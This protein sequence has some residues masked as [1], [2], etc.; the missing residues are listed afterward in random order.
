MNFISISISVIIICVILIASRRWAIIAMTAGVL[1]LTQHISVDVLGFNIFPSR[2]ME[3]AG[4][5]RIIA[6]REFSFS[7]LN[8]IDRIFLLLYSYSTI[9]FILRSNEGQA[10]AIGSA[11][12]ATFCYFIFRGLISDI[13][14]FRW[15]LR[16][17]A[18]LL[19]P[20]VCLLFVEMQTSQNPFSLLG[21]VLPEMFREGRVRCM[22]SFRHP[23]LMGSLGASF[24]PLYIGLI[25]SRSMRIYATIG[26]ILCLGIVWFSNSGGPVG[27]AA[28]GVLG[29]SMWPY[30]DR[31]R[32]VRRVAV[33]CIAALVLIMKAPIWYL[34]TH[35]SISGDAW[36]R[37]HLMDVAVHHLGEW[38]LW[39]MPLTNTSEWFAYG[40]GTADQADITNQFVSFGLS[41][42][43]IS[44]V[45]FV[46][47]LTRAF[48]N[49]GRKLAEMRLA[50]VWSFE[51]ECL[52]WGL[53]VMLVGHITNFLAITYFDQFYVIWFMQLAF[54]SNLTMDADT[55]S[56]AV[57]SKSQSVGQFG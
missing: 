38:W 31:M 21:K 3:I 41:A 25:F 43:L 47:L 46:W 37:S 15:F 53:G 4:L 2:F 33:I 30:R 40:L 36:H 16:A 24:L 26:I 20:Y 28:A 11:V 19:I 6:R 17:F 8:S 7:N 13:D 57:P 52:L 42:G 27:F 1:Y 39:G 44:I 10:Y 34:P 18:I 55:S 22:G 23:S 5:I 12:D 54:I 50:T 56:G 49:L 45:M 14:D 35:F 29:W 9:T 32:L 51:S 48:Q